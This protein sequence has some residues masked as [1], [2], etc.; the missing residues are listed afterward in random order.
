MRAAINFIS[1]GVF[2]MLVFHMT[3]HK[4]V[5]ETNEAPVVRY[6]YSEG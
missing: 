2:L 1:W 5:A 3:E 4:Q 6:V